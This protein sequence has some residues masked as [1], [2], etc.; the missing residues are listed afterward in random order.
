MD[1]FWIPLQGH[2]DYY[3]H[4][5]NDISEFADPA[6]FPEMTAAGTD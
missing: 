5:G 6:A 4:F 2:E 3:V 1:G